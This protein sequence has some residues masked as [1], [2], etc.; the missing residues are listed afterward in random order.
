MKQIAVVGAG[1]MGRFHAATLD[2]LP[3]VELAAIA[4]P[5]PHPDLDRFD[6]PVTTGPNTTPRD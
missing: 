6:A 1:G 2:E 4:D 3:G 5:Y